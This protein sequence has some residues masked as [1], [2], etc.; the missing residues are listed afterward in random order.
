MKVIQ[1]TVAIQTK[2][3]NDFIDITSEIQKVA[4][5]SKVKSGMM[6]VN[7]L[8]NTAAMIIQ[9]DDPSIHRDLINTLE[10]SVPNKAKYEH[11]FEGNVNATAHLKS[12]LL[13]TSITIPVKDEKLV[14][15]T[16]QRIWFLELFESR[17]RQVVVTVIGE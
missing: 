3:A 15:G 1:K 17:K 6:F 7:S 11:S 5:E 12:N 2:G 10:R 16:W 9:E 8:H 13:G 4:A 14:L